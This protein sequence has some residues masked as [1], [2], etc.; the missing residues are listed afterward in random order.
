MHISYSEMKIWSE[1][2]HRHKLQYIDKLEGFNGNLHTAFG[3]AMHSV[4]EHTLLDPELDKEKHFLEVFGKEIEKLATKGVPIEEEL[5]QA[6]L[7]QHQAISES[8]QGA[9]DEYFEDCEVISMEEKLYE[10]IEHLDKKFKG[11]I[12]LV[13]K[14]KDGKYH[15]LDWKTCGWGWDAR[16]KADKIVN[17]Q[18]VLYKYFWAK[19]HG[20]P[21]E[22]IETHFGL[23]KRTAKKNNTEIFRVTSGN[24]KTQNATKLVERA[25]INIKKGVTLKNRLSCKYCPFYKTEHCK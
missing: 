2:P 24:R 13:V 20:I 22:N 14:T 18:I 16:K 15:I 5:Y 17:Y 8:F 19:K 7:T 12:D 9:L 11:F 25:I 4:C 10:D 3:T 6:M 23:L 21:L 1:C